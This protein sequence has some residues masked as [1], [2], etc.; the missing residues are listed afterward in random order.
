VGGA[1]LPEG[2]DE[3]IGSEWPGGSLRLGLVGSSNDQ[4]LVDGLKAI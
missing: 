4:G 2:F 1:G 3:L